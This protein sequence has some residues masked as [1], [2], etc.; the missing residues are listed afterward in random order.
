MN[1][2]FKYTLI[3]LIGM[4]LGCQHD[5]VPPPVKVPSQFP[6]ISKEYKPVKNLPY[7]AWWL[8]LHDNDLNQLIDEGLQKNLDLRI[9]INN[10]ER[11]QGQLQEVKLGWLPMLQG[12]IGYSTNP[13]LGIPG[14][15]LGLGPL[16]AINIAQQ[17]NQNKREK[18]NVQ[19]Y[20]AMNQGMRLAVIGQI[21]STYFTLLEQREELHLL[22]L[23]N[24]DIKKLFQILDKELQA[25]LKNQLDLTALLVEKANIAA[26]LSVI[27]HNIVVSQNALRFLVN[28]NPGKIKSNQ[29]F[30]KIDFTPFKPGMIPIAVLRNRP[31]VKM[32]RFAVQ[33][34][35]ANI[36]IAESNF[37]PVLQLDEVIGEARQPRNSLFQFTDA[38]LNPRIS[39]STLGKMNAEKG[40]YKANVNA[41]IKTVRAVLNEVDNDFSANKEST[42][43][44][45]ETK[46]AT[47]AS[48]EKYKLRKDLFNS[49][50]TSYHLI[51]ESKVQFEYQELLTSHA[52]LKLALSLV[53]LY[54]DLAAGYKVR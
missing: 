27:K 21:I 36:S 28:A 17:I 32:A 47:Q 2:K 13:A 35:G 9:A 3:L 7:D 53:R 48:F 4:L 25:G 8:K 10:L 37:F 26:Q 50:L 30:D 29:H 51:L 54:Q 49:G 46:A 18:Y 23:L 12:F 15:F 43:Y 19:Y 1:K 6:S 41:Y 22:K 16:Y 11:A 20:H 42:Q 34:A 40:A 14:A 52:K 24:H 38:Y 5:F 45:L 44:Y 39:L 31:D 33:R